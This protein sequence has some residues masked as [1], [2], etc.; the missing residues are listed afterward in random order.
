MTKLPNS[1]RPYLPNPMVKVVSQHPIKTKL[2]PFFLNFQIH[3]LKKEKEW[4]K[5]TGELFP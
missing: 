1:F 4:P 2:G 5:E 3:Y